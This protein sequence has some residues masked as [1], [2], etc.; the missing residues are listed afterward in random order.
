MRTLTVWVLVLA[1][2]CGEG[3]IGGPAEPGTGGGA[4]ASGGGGGGGGFGGGTSIGGSGGGSAT[5]G[6][7]GG[8]A[9][10]GGGGGAAATVTWYRDV[11]PVAQARCQSCHL[12]GGV[13]PFSLKTF[14]EAK[15]HA[16][17]M[18]AATA[19]R[20]M[21]PWMP[22]NGC[23]SYVDTRALTQPEIDVFGAWAAQGAVEGNPA[24]APA[25]VVP[26][27]LTADLTIDPGVDYTPRPPAGKSDDYHCFVMN[28]NLTGD[29]SVTAYEIVPGVKHEVHHVALFDAPLADATASDAAEAGPGWTCFG[30]G[31]AGATVLGSWVPGSPITRHPENTAVRLRAGHA[32][33]MQVHYNTQNG[34]VVPDRTKLKLEFAKG[35]A[36]R[37][38]AVWGVATTSFTI[39]P[40]AI[41]YPATT[42]SAFPTNG[43]LFGVQPHMHTL[44]KHIRVEMVSGGQ[45]TCLIDVPAWNFHWQQMYFFTAAGG[46]ELPQGAQLKVS[47][48]W[49]N[50]GSQTVRYGEGTSDE[51]CGAG[52]FVTGP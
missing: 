37:E 27:V 28:P 32:L 14:A 46:L 42:A 15:P 39:P 23:Q 22:A 6:T 20:R 24:D 48:T 19:M 16:A 1:A 21:P 9:S 35:G 25:P 34:P 31:G 2:G 17:A 40:N 26:Q 33:I 4:A 44:G 41:N 18:A 7:G 45:T 38:A 10:A 3:M 5:P 29:M 51:M 11:L 43:R 12:T 13:A 8:N 47:C 36:T 49:D 50:P 52:L 30:G